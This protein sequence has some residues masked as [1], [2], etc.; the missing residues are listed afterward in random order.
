[1]NLAFRAISVVIPFGLSACLYHGEEATFPDG[2]M[3][4]PDAFQYAVSSSLNDEVMLIEPS[5]E[6]VSEAPN[7]NGTGDASLLEA[8]TKYCDAGGFAIIRPSPLV[9]IVPS[10]GSQIWR[11]E[12]P[13]KQNEDYLQCVRQHTNETFRATLHPNAL[14]PERAENGTPLDLE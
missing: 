5:D 7:M 1:M 2:W 13:A 9:I 8:A 4:R 12:N 6:A 11:S 14:G 3:E 10:A